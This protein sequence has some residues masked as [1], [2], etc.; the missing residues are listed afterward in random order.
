MTNQPHM[1]T[2]SGLNCRKTGMLLFDSVLR[3]VFKNVEACKLLREMRLQE[4][5]DAYAGIPRD[6][7]A[8]CAELRTLLFQP[9]EIPPFTS[10]LKRHMLHSGPVP[11]E[12]TGFTFWTSQP[13]DPYRIA[14][15]LDPGAE[16]VPRRTMGPRTSELT[17][18]TYHGEDAMKSHALT[19]V[20]FALT[21]T[22]SLVST[23][24]P[25]SDAAVSAVHDASVNGH[26][27]SF[28]TGPVAVNVAAPHERM[29]PS[30]KPAAPVP[31]YQPPHRQAPLYGL[32]VGGGTR[33]RT[34]DRLTIVS[35]VPDHTGLTRD[36]HPTLY[37]H[38]ADKLTVP[39][40]FTMTA[41]AD[42]RVLVETQL[43][44]P[45][46]P[47]IQKVS[48]ADLGITLVEGERYSWSIALVMDP[49]HRSKDIV[50]S[51]SIE[52]VA[53]SH[54]SFLEAGRT[55]AE[56][57]MLYARTGLWYDA[58]QAISDSIDE[59]PYDSDL[60]SIRAAFL[61]QVRLGEVTL[62]R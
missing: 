37:W 12:L 31:V 52:R 5:V 45:V 43:P 24:A 17:V 10:Q 49:R 28:P 32:R 1:T 47:G 19:L 6:I 26:M 29:L 3:L 30:A 53:G 23:P 20:G 25:A 57:A 7:Y 59:R 38:T 39:I 27:L 2:P 33:A 41:E 35:L 11:I 4:E 34:G 42:D 14:I 22:L 18:T 56:I 58:F 13:E 8:L 15:F 61:Q 60:R 44:A 48:L 62:D 16:T 9:A 21:L 46:R 54:D 50:A 40:E 51:G 36:M 55:L